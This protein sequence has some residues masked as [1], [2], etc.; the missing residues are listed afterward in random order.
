[1]AREIQATIQPRYKIELYVRH[2]LGVT[3]RITALIDVLRATASAEPDVAAFLD[4]MEDGRREGPRQLLGPLAGN[5]KL[6]DGLTANDVAD[7]VFILA[8]PDALRSLTTR[9]GWEPKRADRWLTVLL[10]HEL[11]PDG[12]PDAA[13]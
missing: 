2:V 12:A 7:I 13:I 6:R 11:L 9:C 5:G 8:S 10:L 1:M 3:P 4:Q